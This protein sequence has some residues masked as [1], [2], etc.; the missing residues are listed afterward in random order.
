[1]EVNE[2][3]TKADML[4]LKDELLSALSE[5][6]NRTGSVQKRWL[7]SN[8]VM[9]LLSVSSSGLQNLRINGT[10][11]F[12]KLGGAHYYDYLEILKILETNKS[13]K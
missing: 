11:P 3:V 7:K 8:E 2:L 10:I 6:M 1:M 13:S 5:V 9:E 4:Q 12:T